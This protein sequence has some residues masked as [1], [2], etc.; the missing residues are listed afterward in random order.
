MT[1]YR[2]LLYR[3][4]KCDRPIPAINSG[5]LPYDSME[6]ACLERLVC[7]WK[8]LVLISHPEQVLPINWTEKPCSQ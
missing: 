6:I 7:K 1:E 8:G 5:H 4:P 3:C 2:V